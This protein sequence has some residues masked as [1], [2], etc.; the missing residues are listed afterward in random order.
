MLEV[1]A[2]A[3]A[4]TMPVDLMPFGMSPNPLDDLLIQQEPR[5]LILFCQ[6]LCQTQNLLQLQHVVPEQFQ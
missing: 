6:L 5:D 2:T 3:A 1:A 4:A